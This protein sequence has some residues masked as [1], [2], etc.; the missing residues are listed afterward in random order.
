MGSYSLTMISKLILHCLHKHRINKT[1]KGKQFTYEIMWW[2]NTNSTDNYIMA[3]KRTAE[4]LWTWKTRFNLKWRV[5]CYAASPQLCALVSALLGDAHSGPWWT[6]SPAAVT[7]GAPFPPVV[8]SAVP[9]AAFAAQH[10]KL[11]V[12]N[13]E[14]FWMPFKQQNRKQTKAK[15]MQSYSGIRDEI[16]Y[17]HKMPQQSTWYYALSVGNE[18]QESVNRCVSKYFISKMV[19]V[20]ITDHPAMLI[21][22]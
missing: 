8:S 4:N 20:C 17:H 19:P 1:Y 11:Q 14:I 2:N 10:I 21:R 22:I 6:C 18:W 15:P 7:S 16:K 9:P 5:D 12:Q 13:C 3:F